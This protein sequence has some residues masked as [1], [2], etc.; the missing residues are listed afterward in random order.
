MTP[1]RLPHGARRAGR[2]F[3]AALVLGLL[4]LQP[5]VP[6]RA[7]EPPAAANAPAAATPAAAPAARAS[8]AM[9]LGAS[10]AATHP[11]EGPSFLPMGVALLLVLALMGAA[12][13]VLRRAGLAPQG[14][15]NRL[16]RVVSQLPLGPRERIVIVE[17]GERWLLLGV[18]AG[19]ISRLASLPKGEAAGASQGAAP[20]A[21]LLDRLRKGRTA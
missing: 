6:A 10:G 13:W 14:G 15:D 8:T 11:V 12:V 16:L 9:P 3:A 17:A 2:G 19:G 21:A 1:V 18:G 4:L 20:F 7:D 5:P